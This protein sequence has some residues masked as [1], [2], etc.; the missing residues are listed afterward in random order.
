[1]SHAAL[2]VIVTRASRSADPSPETDGG[3]LARFAATRDDGAFT[4]LV[5]RL[6]PMVLGVC[7]RVA[8]DAHLAEDAFQ[9]AF[10]VLAR[11]AADVRPP[12]AVRGWLYGVAVRTAQ[13]ARAM[14]ARRLARE[15]PVAEVPDRAHEP[16]EPPDADALCVLDEEVAALPE[17]L[18]SA[19]VLC[20]LDGLSRQDAAAQ[21]CI[22][23][24]TLSSR[25]AKAR[26]VLAAR[27]KRRGLVLPAGGFT[28]LA[29][30]TVPP[31]LAVQASTFSISGASVPA[32]VAALT[33]KV[34]R[35]MLLSRL[36][37]AT[38]L[39][40]LVAGLFGAA[41]LASAPSSAEPPQTRPV[42][43]TFVPVAA[44][45]D[46]KPL[47]KGPNKVLFHRNGQLALIDPDGKNEAKTGDDNG[48]LLHSAS[49][50]PD[51][52]T[53]AALVRGPVPPENGPKRRPAILH[54]RGLE[55]KEPGTDLGVV[56]HMLAWSPDG[57]EILCCDFGENADMKP[58]ATSTIVNVKTKEKRTLKLPND[59]LLMDWSRDGKFFLT[60]RVSGSPEKPRARLYLMNPDGTEHK[61][62]T[63]ENGMSLF[64]RLS[65]DGTRVL[66]NRVPVGPNEK[67]DR[68]K[69]ELSVVDVANGKVTKVDGV[70][71][72]GAVG[73][74]CWASNSKRIAYVWQQVHEGKPE[75]LVK[76]ETE[77]RVIVCDADGKNPKAIVSEKGEGQWSLTLG[78]VDWR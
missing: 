37:S 33:Q 39:V 53:V 12:E 72:S 77:S 74:Y 46:P 35:T 71:P 34:F 21:L 48:K 2:S 51:G 45:A 50:S 57:T 76:K 25:L 65:P 14:S 75:D 36:K 59:Q 13:E 3:L 24:G 78:S 27:L 20:E 47:P 15:V 41:V 60:M 11:R 43:A 5:R 19:V 22:P 38:L 52:K 44:K 67:P 7:R 8:G 31:L 64:G 6:G 17:R 49:L 70:P 28:V 58:E 9:A 66:F 4:E 63:E 32:G 23:E 62:L 26:K 30:A 69:A 68:R 61:A 54:V 18:R 40:P 73:G 55:E 1:M 16:A 10:V 42:P 56:G 29:H